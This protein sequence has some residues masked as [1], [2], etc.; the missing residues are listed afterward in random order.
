MPK[1]GMDDPVFQAGYRAALG[2][3][4]D[5][6]ATDLLSVSVSEAYRAAVDIEAM[7]AHLA[8]DIP[9]RRQLERRLLAA[10]SQTEQ[11]TKELKILARTSALRKVGRDQARADLAT[12]RGTRDQALASL[13]RV[14]TLLD[15]Y[16]VDATS[17]PI[18]EIRAAIAGRLALASD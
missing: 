13:N 4:S 7:Q 18:V 9:N 6:I 14:T 5:A 11:L 8:S 16:E 17:V 15:H 2:H 3:L 12:S 1:R 10:S